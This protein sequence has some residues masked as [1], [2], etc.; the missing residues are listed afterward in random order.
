[1]YSIPLYVPAA[2]GKNQIPGESKVFGYLS[3]QFQ[4]LHEVAQHELVS[5]CGL[6]TFCQVAA[7]IQFL[8]HQ[9]HSEE[10]RR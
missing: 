5:C 8:L 10:K 3:L 6:R 9:A 7:D 2:Y 1:M 4:S